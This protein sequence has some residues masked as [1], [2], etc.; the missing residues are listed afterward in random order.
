MSEA[1]AGVEDLQVHANN[2]G[3][4]SNFGKSKCAYCWIKS[5]ESNDTDGDHL[6]VHWGYHDESRD[7]YFT[8]AFP[9]ARGV[10]DYKIQVALKTTASL[11]ENNIVELGSLALESETAGNVVSYN[12]WAGESDRNSTNAAIGGIDFRGEQLQFNLLEGNVLTTMHSDL[13]SFAS[14]ET[15]AY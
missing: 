6:E 7:S 10:Q 1:Y 3:Y 4:A 14:G 13:V 15:T 5:V 2:S 8:S 12:Y 9:R 11:V